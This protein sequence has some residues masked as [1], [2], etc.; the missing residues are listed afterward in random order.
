M[1]VSPADFLNI[2]GQVYE[3]AVRQKIE[4]NLQAEMVKR[5]EPASKRYPSDPR[6]FLYLGDAHAGM[7]EKEQ[8]NGAYRN[9]IKLAQ[10]G[11]GPF[12]MEERKEFIQKVTDRL[13]GL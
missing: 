7:E 3:Q 9:A 5:F 4:K 6:M 13:K 12:S 11:K 1:K 8:A 10:S 2:L